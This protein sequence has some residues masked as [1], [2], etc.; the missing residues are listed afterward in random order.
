VSLPLGLLLRELES[1]P[2]AERTFAF[3][4]ESEFLRSNCG[5]RQGLLLPTEILIAVENS[6]ESR[7]AVLPL[8][9]HG[10][11]IDGIIGIG[12]DGIGIDGIDIIY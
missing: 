3:L 10:I 5:W 8:G 1:C 12:S 9:M 2:V 6:S 7:G 4:R 11:E